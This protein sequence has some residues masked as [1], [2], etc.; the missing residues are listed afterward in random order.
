M[1]WP[2][3]TAQLG[4]AEAAV[5]EFDQETLRRILE[6]LLPEFAVTEAAQD[7]VVTFGPR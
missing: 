7:N 5:R 3:L 2:L 4:K 6:Q 1:A